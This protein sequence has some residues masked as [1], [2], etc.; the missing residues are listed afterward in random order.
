MA[1]RGEPVASERPETWVTFRT[2]HMGYSFRFLAGVS[3]PWKKRDGRAPR[4]VA[5]LLDW[6]SDAA[7]VHYVTGW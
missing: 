5:R 3:M 1:L 7:S 4:F 2:G 6:G